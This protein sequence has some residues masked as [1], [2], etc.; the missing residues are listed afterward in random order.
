MSIELALA[1]LLSG[2]AAGRR[3]WGFAEN[4]SAEAGPYIVLNRVSGNRGYFIPR[5]SGFV[6]SRFQI[7]IY[8]KSLPQIVTVYE[9]IVST[10]SG[11]RGTVEGTRIAATFL[12]MPRD[13]PAMS[14]GKVLALLRR[15]TDVIFHHDEP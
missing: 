8:A 10:L 2:V 14:A 5:P 12:E 15:S 11:Y 3:D 6:Q 4:I 7:D 1:S 9:A 13:L